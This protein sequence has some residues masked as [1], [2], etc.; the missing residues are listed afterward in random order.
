MGF[1]DKVKDAAGKAA[2]KAKH[3]TAAGKEK[4]EDPISK[5]IHDLSRRSASSSS[6][7]GATKPPPIPT[8][9]STPRSSR[10]PRSRS[11]SRRTASPR[12]GRRL[13]E[14]AAAGD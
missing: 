14:R 7:S 5:Q 11:R 2:E 4:L 6:R 10:S 9:R 12:R 13:G 1:L 3:V 8:R